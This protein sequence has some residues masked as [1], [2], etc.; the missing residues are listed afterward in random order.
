[1]DPGAAEAALGWKARYDFETGL[2]QTL[3]W[4]LDNEAWWRPIRERRYAGERLGKTR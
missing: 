4:Y 3:G 1:M 2:V